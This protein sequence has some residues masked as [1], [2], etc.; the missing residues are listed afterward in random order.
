VSPSD[1]VL[2]KLVSA[3]IGSNE[4][5]DFANLAVGVK[6]RWAALDKP[7]RDACFYASCFVSQRDPLQD[8]RWGDSDD[9]LALRSSFQPTFS[10]G[11][12]QLLGNTQSSAGCFR[13]VRSRG[14]PQPTLS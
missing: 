7:L 8:D 3:R 10:F 13:Q 1:D 4:T 5:A 2:S 12:L 9:S 6:P 11:R 14:P